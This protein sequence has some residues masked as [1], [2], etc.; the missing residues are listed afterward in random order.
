MQILIMS[1]VLRQFIQV[2]VS[3]VE[4][5]GE[6]GRNYRK[7]VDEVPDILEVSLWALDQLVQFLA[8]DEKAVDRDEEAGD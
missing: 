6:H 4:V 1:S 3:E 5:N 7:G 8:H 2:P